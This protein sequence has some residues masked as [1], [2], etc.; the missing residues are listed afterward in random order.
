MDFQPT[1]IY[2]NKLPINELL[3]IQAALDISRKI[4]VVI[5]AYEPEPGKPGIP[6]HRAIGDCCRLWPSWREQLN[7]LAPHGAR[8]VGDP[9]KWREAYDLGKRLS[10][11]VDIFGEGCIFVFPWAETEAAFQRSMRHVSNSHPD[12]I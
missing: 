9:S 12:L 2:H 8:I 6:S 7:M 1:R 5:Q 3:G 4:E 10:V 11:F